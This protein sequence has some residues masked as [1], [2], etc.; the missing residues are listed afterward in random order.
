VEL[1]LSLLAFAAS[2]LL[3]IAPAAPAQTKPGPAAS[4]PKFSEHTCPKCGHTTLYTPEQTGKSWACSRCQH[5]S[6]FPRPPWPGR[7]YLPVI[8]LTLFCVALGVAWM[9]LKPR[10]RSRNHGYESLNCPGCN[11]KLRYRESQ[12][13]QAGVCP[14]CDHHFTFPTG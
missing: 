3:A 7:K 6:T 8:T 10:P 2:L 4:P 13:G 5:V 11:R 1:R 14:R 12:A 9:I